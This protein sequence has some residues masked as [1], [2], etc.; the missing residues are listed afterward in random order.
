MTGEPLPR[1]ASAV[2]WSIAIGPGGVS[3][4]RCIV[5]GITEADVRAFLAA[6]GSNADE[7]LQLLRK[8]A[9]APLWYFGI[10]RDGERRKVYAALDQS[11]PSIVAVDLRPGAAP[12]LKVYA[13]HPPHM[14]R[15]AFGS[16]HPAIAEAF[17]D[18]DADPAMLTDV[19]TMRR[20]ND[21]DRRSLDVGLRADWEAVLGGDDRARRRDFCSALL[22]AAGLER[23]SRDMHRFL[24]SIAVTTF[25]GFRVRDD[26][27]S[28]HLWGFSQPIVRDE[29]QVAV[30]M[31]EPRDWPLTITFFL[32]DSPTEFH[33]RPRHDDPHFVNYG[34]WMLDYTALSIASRDV[35]EEART[36]GARAVAAGP[37]SAI[38]DVIAA[39]RSSD[40]VREARIEAW[41]RRARSGRPT[42]SPPPP[43]ARGLRDFGR[44]LQSAD[45]YREVMAAGID[46]IVEIVRK[47]GE[48]DVPIR[49][50]GAAHSMGGLTLPVSGEIL[51]RTDA[52]KAIR[53][54][55]DG[56]VTAGA[57][58]GVLALR[59]IAAAHGFD[60][61]VVNDGKHGPTV[62]G[63]LAAGGIGVGSREHGGFWET[64]EEVTLVDGAGEVRRI[65]RQDPDFKWIFGSMGQLGIVI[66]ARIRLLATASARDVEGLTLYDESPTGV[67]STNDEGL[68]WF[69]LFVPPDDRAAAHRELEALEKQ[70]AASFAYE[71]RYDY[72][73]ARRS[74]VPPLLYDD[75]EFLA[76]G[77]WGHLLPGNGAE[78]LRR[79]SEEVTVAM[80]RNGWRRYFQS[81]FVE[82]AAKRR[83]MLPAHILLAFAEVKRRFDPRAILNRG[84]MFD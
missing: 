5:Y 15:E 21:V 74:F 23:S 9:G 44:F 79:F 30:R 71:S 3:D 78:V 72:P 20:G 6:S 56:M 29:E 55:G 18:V 67:S 12:E 37:P 11:S 62:A 75:V 46:E 39:L 65:R 51:L 49:V 77:I 10:G 48:H 19:I 66:E 35:T 60:V 4:Q 54:E 28:L 24:D 26:A 47:A 22:R 52:L 16:V 69:T 61:S 64:I 13:R 80:Q 25:A 70:F 38:L 41:N 59:D 83:S 57:G 34:E 17:K 36:V 2:E 33:L 14:L 1:D 7:V 40:A 63:Y 76:T 73:I 8:A 58:V 45:D 42:S 27:L 82:G 50:R 68:Y 84:V 43:G 53:F 32:R 31:F 81:E